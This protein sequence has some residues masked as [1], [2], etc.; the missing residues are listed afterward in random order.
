[1]W[2]EMEVIHEI[3]STQTEEFFINHL[4]IK[5]NALSQCPKNCNMPVVHDVIAQKIS[6]WKYMIHL[7]GVL[8]GRRK[9]DT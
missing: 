2:R 5:I 3:N 8:G 4:S 7:V 9:F 1:M 6:S